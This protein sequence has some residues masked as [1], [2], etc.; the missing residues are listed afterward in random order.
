MTL[1][2]RL[3]IACCS[4]LLCSGSDFVQVFSEKLR[5]LDEVRSI[6]LLVGLRKEEEI[7]NGLEKEEREKTRG[8]TE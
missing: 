4:K 8:R 3:K 5:S 1:L 2:I 6:E 7:E